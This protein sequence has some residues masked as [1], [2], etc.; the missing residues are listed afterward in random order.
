MKKTAIDIAYEYIEKKIVNEEW[1]A[2]D[3]ITPE[4]KLAEELG[5]SR[6]SVRSAIE[7]L[8]ALNILTKKKGGGSYVNHIDEES[9]LTNLIP[10]M[11]IGGSSYREILEY[12]TYMDVLAVELFIKNATEDERDNLKNI[13]YSMSETK[14]GEKFFL[15]DMKFHQVIA[16][17]SKNK[18]LAKI[19]QII[20]NILK[21]NYTEQYH[22]LPS[23]ERIEEHK[24]ILDAILSKDLEMAKLTTKIHILRSLRDLTKRM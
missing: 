17:G 11:T 10:F 12:R 9:Y 7:K 3:K 5:I 21:H 19:N 16:S 2:G 13:F 8:V 20:F 4:L 18:M 14:N 22:K 15:L 24:K 6:A 1:K 23:K